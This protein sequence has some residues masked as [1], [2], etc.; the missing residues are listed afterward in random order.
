MIKEFLTQPTAFPM[1]AEEPWR[2]VENL[3]ENITHLIEILDDEFDV[4]DGVAIHQSAIIG[5]NVTIKAPAIISANCFV[6]SNSYRV[7]GS[8]WLLEQ[9]WASAVR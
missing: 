2:I 8:S 4:K 3:C 5:H 1:E 9:R 6:G 7:A